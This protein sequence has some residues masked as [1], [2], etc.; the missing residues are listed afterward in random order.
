[1]NYQVIEEFL[2]K[3]LTTKLQDLL[4]VNN[5]LG[6]YDLFGKYRIIRLEDGR[7][8][9]KIN[10]YV[11]FTHF[12]SLAHAVTWCIYDKNKRY[13]ELRRIEELDETLNSLEFEIEIQ[14]NC[15][16]RVMELDNRYV[17]MAKLNEAKFRKNEC[18]KRMNQ[19]LLTSKI[20]QKEAFEESEPK[21][22]RDNDKYNK[23]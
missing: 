9:V 6:G 18:Q 2:S 15:L 19:Y 20:W 21:I 16:K 3:E 13:W 8:S 23:D 14:K 17:Y 7:Y 12:Y 4:I 1:M 10:G 11:G 22:Y 5:K